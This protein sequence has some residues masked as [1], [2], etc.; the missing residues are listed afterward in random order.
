MFISCQGKVII[1]WE[2]FYYHG[3]NNKIVMSLILI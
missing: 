1:I 2:I 3:D